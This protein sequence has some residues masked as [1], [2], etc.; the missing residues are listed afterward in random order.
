LTPALIRVRIMLLVNKEISN[1]VMYGQPYI[2][3]GRRARDIRRADECADHAA[4]DRADQGD[5]TKQERAPV[6]GG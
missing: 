1:S 2:R 3:R 4:G 5:R 6:I